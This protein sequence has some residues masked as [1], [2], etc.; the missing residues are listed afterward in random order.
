VEYLLTHVLTY[1]KNDSAT[2]YQE[3]LKK[4]WTSTKKSA[5]KF[6]NPQ[7]NLVKSTRIGICP[8]LTS[9]I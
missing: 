2:N 5:K 9:E 1:C 7:T 3:E 4:K 6:E 8:T